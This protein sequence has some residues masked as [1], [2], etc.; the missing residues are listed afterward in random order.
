MFPYLLDLFFL[1]FFSWVEDKRFMFLPSSSLGE[2][3]AVFQAERIVPFTVELRR[4]GQWLQVIIQ[5]YKARGPPG[6]VTRTQGTNLLTQ[7][8]SFH[9]CPSRKKVLASRSRM[10]HLLEHTSISGGPGS[11]S[12][13]KQNICLSWAHC[14]IQLCPALT[15]VSF[16]GELWEAFGTSFIPSQH[17]LDVPYF[18]L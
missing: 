16:L 5:N 7:T 13:D 17:Y 11:S 9:T 3:G 8:F 2:W 12:P 14:H 6:S 10:A 1:Y 15:K 18:K 4:A